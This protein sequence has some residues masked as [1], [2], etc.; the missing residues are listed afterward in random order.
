MLPLPK[1]PRGA[2]RLH[3]KKDRAEIKLSED[4]EKAKVRIRDKRCRW[5]RCRHARDT[6][7][8]LEVAHLV[9]KGM[10]GDRFG[11][12]SQASG[13]ILLCRAHHQWDPQE[14][15]PEGSI[16]RHTL[17]IEP[18]TDLGTDGPCRFLRWFVR[19]T[20][21]GLE[22]QWIVWATERSVGILESSL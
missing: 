14:G 11:E 7:I 12:R 15:H 1:P 2:Y 3:R 13:M 8:P 16:E 5:P 20:P 10:G 21:T 6:S 4:T 9:A 18:L 22:D 19:M 17:R